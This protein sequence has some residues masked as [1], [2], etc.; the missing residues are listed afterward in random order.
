MIHRIGHRQLDVDAR[1]MDRRPR[2]V[3]R[4]ADHRRWGWDRIRL[5]SEQR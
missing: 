2:R 5:V 4:G 1:A 3:F